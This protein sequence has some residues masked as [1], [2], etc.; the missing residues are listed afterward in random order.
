V[1]NGVIGVS[2]IRPFEKGWTAT[3][4]RIAA[5]K[6]AV[7]KSKFGVGKQLTGDVCDNSNE[8][9]LTQ[10]NI[11]VGIGSNNENKFLVIR[12]NKRLIDFCCVTFIDCFRE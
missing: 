4:G 11:F 5:L 3:H 1:I 9:L 10:F 7:G 2:L 12:G 8:A 6:C